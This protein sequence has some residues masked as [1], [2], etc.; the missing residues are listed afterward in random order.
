MVKEKELETFRKSRIKRK[1]NKRRL[2]AGLKSEAVHDVCRKRYNS[3]KAISAFLRKE[4][5]VA[6]V[7]P[8]LRSTTTS[9]FSF[10]D[11][12]LLCAVEITAEFI[13]KQKRA[14]QREHCVRKLGMKDNI[15]KLAKPRNDDWSRAIVEHNI[16]TRA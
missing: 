3:E 4:G 16:A 14:H 5:D 12:Y 10:K 15:S 13:A 2:L 6:S 8:Q 7:H 11:H 1:D 9:T